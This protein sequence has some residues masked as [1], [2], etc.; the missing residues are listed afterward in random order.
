MTDRDPRLAANIDLEGVRL[1]GIAGAVYGIGGYF[2]TRFVNEDLFNT[3]A[4]QSNTNT[5]DAPIMKL[6][7]VLLNYL[8]AAAELNDMGAYTLSQKDLDITINEIRK[9]AS[10]NM[11]FRLSFGKYVVKDAS[12]WCMKAFASMIFAVGENCI[13]RI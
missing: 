6:N 2:G 11:K 4:G 12:N 8:E 3:A 10:V 1:N 5:T 7:E 9:R 13:M